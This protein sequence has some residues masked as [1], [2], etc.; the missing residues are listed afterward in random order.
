MLT[1]CFL[2]IM[3]G[4]ALT[5]LDLGLDQQVSLI[6]DSMTYRVLSS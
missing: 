4:V 5:K 1:F 2:I 6:K 3:S